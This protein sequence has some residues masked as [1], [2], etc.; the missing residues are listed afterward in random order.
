[1]K[2]RGRRKEFG[3]ADVLDSHSLTGEAAHTPCAELSPQRDTVPERGSEPDFL[4]PKPGSAPDN[5]C[6]PVQ[7]AKLF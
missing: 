7:D 6:N 3:E 4:S 5:L 2:R 1:M